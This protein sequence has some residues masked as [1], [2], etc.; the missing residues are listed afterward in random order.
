MVLLPLLGLLAGAGIAVA[1][2]QALSSESPAAPAEAAEQR[3]TGSIVLDAGQYVGRPV[4][5]V[6]ARLIRLGLDVEPRAEVRDD[7]MPDLVTGV[8]PHG[9]PLSPGETVVVIYATGDAST[10]ARSRPAVT[11]AAVGGTTVEE[12]DPT[13]AAGEASGSTPPAPR[14]S[15][16]V[17]TL[18]A[19]PTAP[20]TT[21]DETTSEPDDDEST[22]PST[23]PATPPT[24]SPATTATAG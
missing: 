23:S 2:L 11:G 13:T 6:L 9:K 17:I 1:L 15:V 18:P 7:V 3:D 4:E 22:A 21:A 12:E 19:M 10:A 8:E 24:T 16:P 14:I 20:E 5:E